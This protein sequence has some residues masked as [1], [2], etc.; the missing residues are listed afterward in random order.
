MRRCKFP[1]YPR[2]TTK[3]S[4]RNPS[5]IG[6]A[7]PAACSPIGTIAIGRA[8]GAGSSISSASRS[9]P[10]AQ[11]TPA[12]S[13]PPI[14]AISPSYRPPAS[15]VPCEPRSVVTNSKTECV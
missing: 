8:G 6:N 2:S 9:T 12:I 7:F 1:E 14:T 13:G 3:P 15:T 11:P 4:D 10:A 5:A